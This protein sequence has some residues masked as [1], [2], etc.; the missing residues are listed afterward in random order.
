MCQ[1]RAVGR[2]EN[3]GPSNNWV[4]IICQ[5][6]D[7][8]RFYRYLI[9]ALAKIRGGGEG[10]CLLAPYLPPPPG[11]LEIDDVTTIKR[12]FLSTLKDENSLKYHTWPDP[13]MF[14]QALFDELYMLFSYYLLPYWLLADW[15]VPKFF[16]QNS[17]ME[18]LANLSK[19]MFSIK[20]WMTNQCRIWE[21]Y[22]FQDFS[23]R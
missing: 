10:D 6:P 18:I 9:K 14:A 19:N 3:S 15:N 12:L 7:W 2:F 8:D 11:P 5:S 1:F 22:A 16:V 23:R 13:C 4:A 17:Q 21:N 20:A